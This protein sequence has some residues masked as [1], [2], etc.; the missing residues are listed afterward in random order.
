MSEAQLII[1]F[2]GGDA[3]HHT[4][5][6]RALGHSLI[7]F[8]RI[9][10]DGLIF[11]GYDRLP[12]RGERHALAVKAREP[13]IGSATIPFD[14]SQSI[15]LLPLGWWLLQTGAAEVVSYWMTFVFSHLSGRKDEAERAY[16]ALERSRARELSAR[17][18]SEKRWLEHEAGWRDQLFALAN[19][20]ASPA[21][22]AVA[23]VGPSVDTVRVEGSTVQPFLIDLPTADAIRAKGE[24]EI[25]P[26]IELDL[27]IDGFVHHTKK[28][29]VENPERP[30]SFISADVRDPGFDTVPNIYTETAN[31]KGTVRVAAKLGHRAGVLEKIYILD[32]RRDIDN[33]A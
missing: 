18:R 33:A 11:M 32:H 27:H 2:D 3:V 19:R 20:L 21:V 26:L 25:S 31:V 24:L 13:Q 16:E 5:E 9:V 22:Q 17:E 23:P 14:I 15:A 6:M 12:K 1:K 10:S 7:G 28:L 29:N 8:E 30:G 4:V